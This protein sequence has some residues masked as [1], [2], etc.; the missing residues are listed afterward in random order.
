MPPP[1]TCGEAVFRSSTVGGSVRSRLSECGAG[2]AASAWVEPGAGWLSVV[3][4]TAAAA[5]AASRPPRSSLTE[6]SISGAASLVS[7][8]GGARARL[9]VGA[10]ASGVALS[11][12]G[13]SLILGGGPS[14]YIVV[15]ST[16]Y[17]RIISSHLNLYL[18]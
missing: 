16:T 3:C 15:P 8:A 14:K 17:D 2:A 18:M 7:V 9:T 11:R 12:D 5:S 6:L 4:V 13:A 10:M 1:D